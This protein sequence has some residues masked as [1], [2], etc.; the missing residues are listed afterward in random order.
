MRRGVTLVLC[1]LL[2]AGCL[3]L[4]GNSGAGLQETRWVLVE[5]NGE[6]FTSP[7]EGPAFFLQLRKDG[8]MAAWAGC[9]AL[10]GG[11]QHQSGIL[12][13]GPF[14]EAP[15]QCAPEVMAEER[16]VVRALEG[17][18]RYRL[19]GSHLSLLNPIGVVQA[20]FRPE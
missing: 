12:R 5:V 3:S 19:E 1:G 8:S 15:R 16:R 6:G 17:A 2:L 14:D 9:N 20:R 7:V 18:S 11:Y 4:P 13:V 10:R